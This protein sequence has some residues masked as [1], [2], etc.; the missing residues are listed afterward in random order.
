[1]MDIMESFGK[2]S[3]EL[4]KKRKYTQTKDLAQDMIVKS[5]SDKLFPIGKQIKNEM[6]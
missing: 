1:M 2:D 5:G 3:V 6:K 4:W